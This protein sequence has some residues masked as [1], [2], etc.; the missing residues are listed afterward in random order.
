MRV[1]SWR[2]RS[3][4]PPSL[5]ISRYWDRGMGVT[6]INHRT[7]SKRAPIEATDQMLEFISSTRSVGH[8]GIAKALRTIRILIEEFEDRLISTISQRK[9]RLVR[10]L[11]PRELGDSVDRLRCSLPQLVGADP[12]PIVDLLV[13]CQQS[14]RSCMCHYAFSRFPKNVLGH[15]MAQ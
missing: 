8:H 14:G 12:D 3:T 15:C 6:H 7:V 9:A 5:S 10:L 13:L 11:R 2:N 4:R 1:V